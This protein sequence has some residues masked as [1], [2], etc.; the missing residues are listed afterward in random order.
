MKRLFWPA[1]IVVSI[2]AWIFLYQV[3]IKLPHPDFLDLELWASSMIEDPPKVVEVGEIKS[4]D[5]E[6]YTFF[7]NFCTVLIIDTREQF[8]M[9]H[10]YPAESPGFKSNINAIKEFLTLDGDIY[11]IS[12]NPLSLSDFLPR[13]RII[14]IYDKPAHSIATVKATKLNGEKV[15]IKTECHSNV[16]PNNTRK[17]IAMAPWKSLKPVCFKEIILE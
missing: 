12:N 4:S 13:N 2:L 1:M 16:F 11:I 17:L 5:H 9:A 7:V 3:V 6:L 10:V 8:Y 14:Y 15:S